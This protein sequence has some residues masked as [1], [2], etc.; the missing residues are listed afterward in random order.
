MRFSPFA[1]ETRSLGKII[2]K[3]RLEKFG[4]ELSAEKTKVIGFGRFAI[5]KTK[6][7]GH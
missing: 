4:L 2:F 6:K 3:K 7:K 1:A 5:E